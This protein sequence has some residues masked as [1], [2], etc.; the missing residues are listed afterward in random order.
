ASVPAA[1]ALRPMLATSL[2]RSGAITPIE[3]S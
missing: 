3:P 1:T 2:R